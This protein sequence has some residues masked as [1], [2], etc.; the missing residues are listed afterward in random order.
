[1]R[2]SLSADEV[3]VLSMADLRTA[4]LISARTPDEDELSDVFEPSAET[5][6]ALSRP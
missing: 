6:E 3:Y 5:L 1:V 2:N 4:D